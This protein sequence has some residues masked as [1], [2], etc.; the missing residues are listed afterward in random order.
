MNTRPLLKRAGGIVAA[1][2]LGWAALVVA[3]EGQISLRVAADQADGNG[4]VG[5]PIVLSDP[6][7]LGALDVTVLY[8]PQCLVFEDAEKARVLESAMFVHKIIEP[9]KVR[10]GLISTRPIEIEGTLFTLRFKSK[11]QAEQTVVE[12]AAPQAWDAKNAFVLRVAAQSGTLQ[13]GKPAPGWVLV[14]VGAVAVVVLLVMVAVLA[15]I[16][17]RRPRNVPGVHADQ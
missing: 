3:G 17:C 8:D 4:R 1:C 11:G 10:C 2:I 6:N 15:F 9:G 16:L 5:V 13:L 7:G 14:V 12:L